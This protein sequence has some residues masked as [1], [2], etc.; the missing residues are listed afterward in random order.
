MKE[1][2]DDI[3]ILYSDRI[4]ESKGQVVVEKSTTNGFA[5]ESGRFLFL[6][7]DMSCSLHRLCKDRYRSS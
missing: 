7:M 6:Y 2:P 1:T 4:E 5:E 3:F